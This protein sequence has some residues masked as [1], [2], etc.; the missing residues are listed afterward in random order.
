[1]SGER[2]SRTPIRWQ[3]IV[4]LRFAHAASAHAGETAARGVNSRNGCTVPVACR[5]GKRPRLGSLYDLRQN[6]S[7]HLGTSPLSLRGRPEPVE[8]RPW[9]SHPFGVRKASPAILPR[10]AG[11]RLPRRSIASPALSRSIPEGRGA[12]RRS[13][14]PRNDTQG[15]SRLP[16]GDRTQS[17]PTA[18]RLRPHRPSLAANSTRRAEPAPSTAEGARASDV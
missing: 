14:P 7:R 6:A 16:T 12:A 10:A 5:E 1:M 9:Q 15:G 8:G 3:E 2:S 4:T 13:R 18:L 11:R 17:L